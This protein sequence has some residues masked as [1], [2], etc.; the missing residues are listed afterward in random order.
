M[1]RKFS[2][3]GGLTV[4]YWANFQW[5]LSRYSWFLCWQLVD[6]ANHSKISNI[7][8]VLTS[9]AAV[10]AGATI[11]LSTP[12]FTEVKTTDGHVGPEF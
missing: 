1:L 11:G 7:K 2:L 5:S 9:E 12:T 3:W 4:C 10:A 8:Y 6:T